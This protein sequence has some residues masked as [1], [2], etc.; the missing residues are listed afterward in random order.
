[1]LTSGNPTVKDNIA[2]FNKKLAKAELD[3]VIKKVSAQMQALKDEQPTPL[4]LV[5]Q[6]KVHS[7]ANYENVP[8]KVQDILKFVS[9]GQ[10][11]QSITDE[12]VDQLSDHISSKDQILMHLKDGD[13]YLVVDN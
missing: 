8:Y 1:M 3:K 9:A 7:A 2:M 4:E 10:D 12:T 5:Y 11:S 6:Q 13:D